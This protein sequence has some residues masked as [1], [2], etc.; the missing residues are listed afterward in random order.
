MITVGRIFWDDAVTHLSP[1]P[2]DSAQVTAPFDDL[3]D[4]DLVFE[5]ELSAFD[6]A[7][8]FLFKHALLRDVAYESVL[9]AHR[10]EYHRRTARWLADVTAKPERLTDFT[11][12]MSALKPRE[13]A[14][15]WLAYAEGASHIE[16]ARALG[17]RP[18]SLKASLFRARRKFAALLGRNEERPQR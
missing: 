16:I 13:R 2:A 1:E 8:E 9:R 18:K 4:R 12:A 3:L 11:R 7:R 6:S 15:L 17:L 14:M 10:R 5:R